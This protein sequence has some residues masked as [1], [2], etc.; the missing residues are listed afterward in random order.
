MAHKYVFKVK[1]NV[2]PALIVLFSLN[3]AITS[4][5]I[6]IMHK[7]L[8]L[9]QAG[10]E[11]LSF[12]YKFSGYVPLFRWSFLDNAPVACRS[13]WLLHS[14][15]TCENSYDGELAQSRLALFLLVSVKVHT[16]LQYEIGDP[17]KILI[18]VKM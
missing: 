7:T 1:D 14:Y 5:H 16:T 10:P 3:V 6:Y 9:H 18:C 2:A 4:E 17:W 8:T 13:G 11:H 12:P 15:N